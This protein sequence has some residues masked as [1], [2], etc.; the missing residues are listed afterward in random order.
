MK[1][2][3]DLSELVKKG[4]KK[5]NSRSK[6]NNFENKIAKILNKRFNTTDF[7]RTPGSGAFATTHKLPSHLQVYGD[8][9][10]PSNF[11]FIIEAKKGYNKERIC[12]LFNPKS[13]L[14]RMI[15]K[16][17]RESRNANKK[18]LFILSQNNKDPLVVTNEIISSNQDNLLTGN[19]SG[20]KVS[21][22]G[23]DDLLEQLDCFFFS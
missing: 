2:N 7:A 19:I 20:L 3:Y 11:R 12:D 5:I 10:T 14:N 8:L 6:G 1:D 13:D 18:F 23:L 16:A 4:K 15:V 22:I 17:E 9:I 21:I